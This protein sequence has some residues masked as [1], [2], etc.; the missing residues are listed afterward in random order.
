MKQIAV[1][2]D[3]DNA[4]ELLEYSFGKEGFKTLCF[5]DS[6][7]AKNY[8]SINKVDAIITDWMM[9][10]INGVE[11]LLSLSN[12]VNSKTPK[13][14]VSCISN[15]HSVNIAKESGADKYFC[16][17]VKSKELISALILFFT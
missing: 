3:D 6:E 5:N 10:K 11:L 4:T 17:P 1:I 15:P 9:P 8:L 16:K 2:D 13:M 12:S 7:V 14:M